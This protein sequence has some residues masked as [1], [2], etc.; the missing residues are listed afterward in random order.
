MRIQFW[1]TRGSIAA[2]GP[3]TLRYGGN[4]P[5]VDV[6]TQDGTLLIFDAGTG[7]R[8][9]GL[10][11]AGGG[12]VRAY[13]FISH[14]HSDHIQGLPFF[15]PIFL[16]GSH[17]S[18]FGPAGIERSLP[19]ALAGQMELTYFPVPMHE[20]ESRREVNEL[21]E[22]EFTLGEI[23]VRTQY[24]NH[25]LPTLGY[26]VE[27]GGAVLVYATDHEPHPGTLWRPD[28]PSGHFEPGLMLHPGDTRHAEFLRGADLVIHDAQY[29]AAEYASRKNW[30]HSPVEYVLDVALA[31]GARR[32]ALFHHDP[33]RTDAALDELLQRARTYVQ[34]QGASL[35]VL[36]AA[37]GAVLTLAEGGSSESV[38]AAP[39]PPRLAQR[40]R[41]LVADDDESV[42]RLLRSALERDGYAVTEVANG[43]EAVEAAGRQPF[44]LILLDLE[45]PVLDGF[46]ACQAMRRDPRLASIP[47][48]MLTG[49]AEDEHILRGFE[50]GVTDYITKPFTLALVRA[51]VRNWLTRQGAAVEGNG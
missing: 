26:R 21:G 4:T 28:R 40:A 25:T 27:A 42:L 11:L 38:T 32:L 15:A 46:S 5:C 19:G 44:D 7:I 23:R 2:P 39:R 34:E 13:L 9:L 37:E 31:A 16:A 41:V 24:L 20:L 29:T 17:L 10:A 8:K 45:M 35:E 50:H 49:R 47:I 30:G 3:E 18:I 51:R 33:T 12:P 43:A 22:Q 6:R 48:V 14:T 1:G 36:V